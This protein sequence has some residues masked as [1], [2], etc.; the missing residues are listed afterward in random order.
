MNVAIVDISGRVVDRFKATDVRA[1]LDVA[2]LTEGFYVLKAEGLGPQRF[3]V[4]H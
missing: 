3:A 4:R 2:T 1:V